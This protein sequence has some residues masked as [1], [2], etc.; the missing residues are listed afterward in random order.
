MLDEAGYAV[1]E[2]ADGAAALR[3]F[4]PAAH[5]AVV[6]DL[7]MP[8]AD[9]LALL[10]GVLK[11]APAM[12]VIVVTAHG[13]VD[14][15]VEA[16]KGGAFDYV[17]KPLNRDEFLHKVG[18]AADRTRAARAND[19]LSRGL[20]AAAG[21]ELVGASRAVEGLREIIR[22]AAASD[23]SVLVT[24][25]SGTGKEVIARAIHFSSPRK[26][27]PF[28]PIDCAAIPA[29]L[30]EAEL[31][32]H[33]R[34]A[35]TGA[36]ADRRGRFFAA[37]GGTAFL[38]EIGEMPVQLQ[39]KLLRFL[40]DQVFERVGGRQQIRVDVR[41]VSA[42]NQP[43]EEQ[44]QTGQ[45]RGDLLYRLNSMTVRVPPLRERGG[46]IVLLARYFLARYVEEFG[47]RIRGFDPGALEALAAHAWPGNVRELQN[48][49]QRAVLMAEGA[50]ISAAELELAT[51]RDDA[52]AEPDL[53]LRNART[54][55]ERETL[56]RA[57][58]LSHGNLA[59]AARML[60]VS[61][62]TLYNLLDAHGIAAA[63]GAADPN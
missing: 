13:G 28:A 50:Q 29:D 4:D 6:T 42:T 48:R 40:Q 24:G 17:T 9:G 57:L 59:Q 11:A 26:A 19:R 3:A 10:A 22:R 37:D 61:R 45:F 30:L 1:D 33:V 39:A 58:A 62:P 43:L 7:R 54:R 47:R 53:D 44:S 52:A 63:R 8:A 38:D 49:V 16:M 23:A 25:E 41:I 12:P 46:D 21:A 35:F 56:D 60:G 2:A 15:A 5:A 27:G 34:G 14:K 36:V 20:L 55:A 31:F 18:N 51:P 32:W